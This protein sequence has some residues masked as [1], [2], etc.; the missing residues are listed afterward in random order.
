MQTI[1]FWK[2]LRARPSKLMP[3]WTSASGNCSTHQKLTSQKCCI[4]EYNKNLTLETAKGGSLR[5]IM[6][7]NAKGC[8]QADITSSNLFHPPPPASYANTSGFLTLEYAV[9]YTHKHWIIQSMCKCNRSHDSNI[10]MH[11]LGLNTFRSN[12]SFD[13]GIHIQSSQNTD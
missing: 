12:M 7:T 5:Q 1:K 8:T 2:L 10:E 3:Q 4:L 13:V 6:T 9:N 11:I